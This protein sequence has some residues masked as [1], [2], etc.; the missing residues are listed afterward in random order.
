MK[1]SVIDWRLTSRCNSTCKFCYAAIKMPMLK[2]D[3]IDSAILKIVSSGC[4]A[5]CISGGEPL[6]E[7]RTLDIIEKLTD[8]GINIYLSTNGTNFLKYRERLEP[9]L[10]KLSMSIDG[11]DRASSVINTR[12][13]VCFDNA[14]DVLD[15]YKNNPKALNFPIKIGTVLTKKNLSREHFLKMYEYLKAYPIA[16]WEIYEFIAEG[17]LA[18]AN[19]NEFAI[20]NKEFEAFKKSI[21]DLLNIKSHFTITLSSSNLRESAYF[22]IQPDG[23]V[24]IPRE[25]AEGNADEIV[26]GNIIEDKMS[27]LVQKWAAVASSVGKHAS[28]VDMRDLENKTSLLDDIDKRLLKLISSNPLVTTDEVT[29]SEIKLSP[30][31]VQKRIK[32]LYDLRAV[33]EIIPIIDVAQLGFEHYLLNL[34]FSKKADIKYV[35][36]VLSNHPNVPWVVECQDFQNPE[37][38]VFRIAL[39]VLREREFQDTITFFKNLEHLISMEMSIVPSQYVFDNRYV[40]SQSA[41]PKSKRGKNDENNQQ[42]KYNKNKAIKLSIEDYNFFSD[43]KQAGTLT[44]DNIG[45]FTDRLKSEG[46]LYKFHAVT[47]PEPIGQR[48]YLAFL[49]MDE[50]QA[51]TLTKKLVDLSAVTYMNTLISENYNSD[52]EFQVNSAFEFYDVWNMINENNKGAITNSKL[53]K[54]IHEHKFNFLIDAV[55]KRMKE[56]ADHVEHNAE[57]WSEWAE[58]NCVWSMPVS[59]EEFVAAQNGEYKIY[60]SPLKPVP[61]EWLGDLRGKKVLG[62]A[63]GGGQQGPILK[64]LGADVTIMDYSDGQLNLENVVAKREGYKMTTV[65]GDMSKKFP[66][67]NEEFDVIFNPISICY[68]SDMRHVWKE[69]SRVL[70]KGGC[71]ITGVTNP[72]LSSFALIDN[73]PQLAYRLPYNP[74]LKSFKYVEGDVE[75]QSIQFS[76]SL[77]DIIEGQAEAGLSIKNF[78]EDYH[79]SAPPK[80]TT[81]T[82]RPALVAYQ[83]SKYMPVFMVIKSIKN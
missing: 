82:M 24:I 28:I 58:D 78:Y 72:A 53:F 25:G 31:D 4:D 54:V 64:A 40:L 11:Y 37:H 43:L 65:L 38:I 36:D 70:K 51:S 26:I 71:L 10:K 79:H 57:L 41:E 16:E 9:N 77:A 80:G 39:F 76:H 15:Y 23:S 33:K 5:V 32:R 83:V 30:S 61:K 45:K 6:L 12:S 2:E 29:G 50:Q 34:S 49:N 35:I 20:T 59:H 42:I 22:I 1:L 21:S 63:S 73:K 68:V 47:N 3:L 52:F 46:F 74:L 17:P 62:L 8:C 60:A 13:V 81:E 19:K 66:F 14:T 55:L 56:I 7:G 69:C 44:A 75:D 67:G 48:K 27:C 18:I